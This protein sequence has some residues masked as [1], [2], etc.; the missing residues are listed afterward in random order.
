MVRKSDIV[1][2]LSVIVVFIFVI[3]SASGQSIKIN[4]K[5]PQTVMAGEQF[6]VDYVIEGDT[7]VKE[8]IIFK[9]MN[10]F[11]ILYGPAVSSSSSV[12]INKGKRTTTYNTVSTYYLEALK[13]GNFSLP[14]AEI[15]F[16]GKKYSSGVSKIEV[17]DPQEIIGE[18]D[19][20]VKTIPSKS[21]VNLSDTLLLTYRLYTTKEISRIVSADFPRI[22]GF[23]STNITRSRQAFTEE[24]INGKTYKVADLR[25]LILQPQKIGRVAIP[26]GQVILEYSVPTGRKVRNMWGEVYDE[27][28]KSHKTVDIEPVNI[29]VQDLKA[30]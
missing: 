13:G 30:I 18:I 8:T 17:K 15:R 21:S 14:K 29:G 28:V 16:N 26:E 6:R 3:L 4:I 11:R 19:V 23:Y 24:K 12:S 9:N 5:A 7:E 27:T 1:R 10:G 2:R 25:V 22:E 20:F